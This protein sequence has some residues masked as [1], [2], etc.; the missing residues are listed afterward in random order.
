MSP[1]SVML[2][3]NLTKTFRDTPVLRNVDLTVE[4]GEVVV[5]LGQS[6]SGK[7]TLLRCLSLA[8]SISSGEIGFRGQL[9][10]RKQ[11]SGKANY[12]IPAAQKLKLRMQIGIVFQQ[13]NLFPHLTALQNVA[14]APIH[15]QKVSRDEANARAR[16]LLEMVGLGSRVDFRSS[17]L[18]GG[19]QQRVAIARTL[20]LSPKLLLFD[21]VTSALDPQMTAEVLAVMKDVALN[22]TTMVVVTHEIGFAKHV[23]T[24]IVFMGDGQIVESGSPEALF[25]DPKDPRT[26]DFL[27]AVLHAN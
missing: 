10:S 20:A 26:K 13:Y 12:S 16:E 23:G 4:A 5:L 9:I 27:S 19:Q 2:V 15:V 1:T 25:G 6:G 7:T 11:I 18:S 24:R 14:L 3:S 21:E 22:G 17:S 8:E